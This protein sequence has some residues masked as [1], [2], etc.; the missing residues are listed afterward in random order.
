MSEKHGTM[1]KKGHSGDFK[2]DREKLV[3]LPVGI[4]RWHVLPTDKECFTTDEDGS[5]P[6][7]W[8][9]DDIMD[10]HK[11]GARLSYDAFETSDGCATEKPTTHV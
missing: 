10:P 7:C 1:T 11:H 9:Y 5:S 2:P 4:A 6:I 8:E 3:P